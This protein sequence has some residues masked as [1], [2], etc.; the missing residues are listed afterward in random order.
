MPDILRDMFI[1]EKK[2]DFTEAYLKSLAF[3]FRSLATNQ[4]LYRNS[5]IK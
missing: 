1:K 5:T 3:P 4:T 2:G